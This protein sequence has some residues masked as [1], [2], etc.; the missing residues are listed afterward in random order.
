M[1][2]LT[3]AAL[4]AIITV[5][6]FRGWLRRLPWVDIEVADLCGHTRFRGLLQ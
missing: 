3:G 4:G 6:Y 2:I 5:L 1:K